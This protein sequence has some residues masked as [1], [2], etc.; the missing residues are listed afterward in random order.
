MDKHISTIAALWIVF[1]ALG[2]IAAFFLFMLLFGVSLLPDIGHEA[3]VILRSVAIGFGIFIAILSLP[4]I[5]AGI[6]L[7]QKKEWARILTLAVAFFNLLSIPFGTAL[8]IYSIIILL[9]DETIELFH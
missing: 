1:G 9:K 2:L 4:E 6:G 5:I 8:G 7:L 3:P